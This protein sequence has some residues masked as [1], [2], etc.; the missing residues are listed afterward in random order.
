[1]SW[2]RIECLAGSPC[3]DFILCFFD[4]LITNIQR[5]SIIIKTLKATP[6]EM[7]NILSNSLLCS[8]NLSSPMNSFL[9]VSIISISDVSNEIVS[10]VSVS[11]ANKVGDFVVVKYEGFGVGMEVGL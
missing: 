11:S 6:M 9:V 1:M 10:D 4:L 8:L 2:L 3:I 5:Q 7:Y